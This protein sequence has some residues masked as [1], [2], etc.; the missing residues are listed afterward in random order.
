MKTTKMIRVAKAWTEHQ[1]DEVLEYVRA[2]EEEIRETLK[3]DAYAVDGTDLIAM[4]KGLNSCAALFRFIGTGEIEYLEGE[5]EFIEEV[6]DLM[7]EGE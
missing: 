2:I 3:D 4:G 1:Q 6:N 7:L 5:D